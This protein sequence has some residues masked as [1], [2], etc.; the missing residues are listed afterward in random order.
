MFFADLE[1]FET[2]DSYFLPVP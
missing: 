2:L 1:P